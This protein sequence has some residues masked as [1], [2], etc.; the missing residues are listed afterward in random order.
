MGY[1]GLWRY[2]DHQPENQFDFWLGEWNLTWVDSNG[3][4]LQF[5]RKFEKDRMILMRDA[6]VRGQ[7]CRQRT[8]RYNTIQER[9]LELELGTLR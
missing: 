5:T 7:A 2:H 3:S 1:S 8:V 4:Y 9:K 6:T